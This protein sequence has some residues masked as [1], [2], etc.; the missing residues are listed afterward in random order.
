MGWAGVR[1]AVGIQKASRSFS[2]GLGKGELGGLNINIMLTI[3]RFQGSG[4]KSG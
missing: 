4:D 3:G 1:W 2:P